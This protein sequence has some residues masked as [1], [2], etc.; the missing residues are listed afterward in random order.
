MNLKTLFFPIAIVVALLVFIWYTKPEWDDYKAKSRD[1]VELNEEKQGVE[2]SAEKIKKA[3]TDMESESEETINLIGNAVPSSKNDDD[4]LAE[5]N[6]N[7][8]QSGIFIETISLGQKKAGKK[9]DCEPSSYCPPTLNRYEIKIGATG[10]YPNLKQFIQRVDSQNRLFGPKKVMMSAN[11]VVDEEGEENS[12]ASLTLVLEG[13]Y[14]SLEDSGSVDM[15]K[16]VISDPIFDSLIKSGL[17]T[18]AIDNFKSVITS[19]Y[20]F[21][22]SFEGAGKINPFSK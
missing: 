9:E 3:K 10:L 15:A 17:N 4:L 5:I 14:Y 12:V 20:F 6:K 22:V 18:N 7:A 21:P 13:Q 2:N 1:L 16:I 8:A 11:R 19:E